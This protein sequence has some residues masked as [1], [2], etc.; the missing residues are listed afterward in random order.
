LVIER[1]GGLYP[2]GD[3][4][5]D[6]VNEEVVLRLGDVNSSVMPLV[7]ALRKLAQP[8]SLKGHIEVTSFRAGDLDDYCRFVFKGPDVWL[9]RPSLWN[10]TQP[11][12]VAGPWLTEPVTG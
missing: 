3:Y 4:E 6:E 9:L 2:Q 12:Q 8:G 11:T 1:P 10:D 7:D 5:I